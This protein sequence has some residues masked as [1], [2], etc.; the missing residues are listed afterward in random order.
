[1]DAI[2]KVLIAEDDSNLR[3]LLQLMFE[4]DF[5]L[6]FASAGDTAAEML[7]E[8]TYDFIILDIQLPV[9]N[10]LDLCRDMQ[11]QPA[12]KKP[13]IMILSADTS[14]NTVKRAYELGVDDYISK[15]FDITIF[16]ERV[17]HFANQITHSKQHKSMDNAVQSVA[18]TA[19]AQSAAYGAGMQLMADLNQCHFEQSMANAVLKYFQSDNIH[20]AIQ[21]RKGNE[22]HTF[23]ID[24][25]V[26]SHIEMQVFELL[27]GHGRIYHFGKRCIFNDRHVSILIKN[28]PQKGSIL[29][30]SVLDVV[31][32]LVPAV[33]ARFLALCD[34]KAL[35]AAKNTLG[36]VMSELSGGLKAMEEDKK[37]MIETLELQISLS[38][39]KLNMDEE[40]E[41]YF[42]NLIEK[43]LVNRNNSERFNKLHE[44][45]S[46]C[47]S[48]LD[49]EI[50]ESDYVPENDEQQ[51]VGKDNDVELF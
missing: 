6:H 50:H 30:D 28:M 45:I 51:D 21:F 49:E 35:V 25:P 18:E 38:F 3:D 5:E 29:H 7:A 31:T 46:E 1:M 12:D 27:R 24:R 2:Q 37:K 32:K 34:H 15:P 8:N 23:D 41:Q 11:Q 22:I 26:C 17:N 13:G 4:S 33:D 43:E 39:H 48:G 47:I 10:G 9:I 36:S 14:E 20:A 42:V 40:Q 19:M 44:M 16:H